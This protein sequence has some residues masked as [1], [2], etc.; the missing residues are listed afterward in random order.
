MCNPFLCHFYRKYGDNIFLTHTYKYPLGTTATRKDCPIYIWSERQFTLIDHVKCLNSYHIERFEIDHEM[1]LAVANF[2]DDNGKTDI[3]S[4]IYKYDHRTQSFQQ[5]QK[6]ETH[7]VDD[8]RHF[9]FTY[10]VTHDDYLIVANAFEVDETG[11]KNYETSSV[12]YKF[13]NGYFIPLQSMV[14]DHVTHVLPVIGKNHEFLLLAACENK[15]V[16]IYQ[17]DGWNFVESTIDYTRLAFGDGVTSLRAYNNFAKAT[18]IGEFFN[19]YD[20]RT[21]I[22]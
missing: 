8:I 14:F 6:I 20:L 18:L 2:E 16:Q 21:Q 15:P 5:Y 11:A 1:Y 13:I 19:F 22:H 7:A 12:I 17:Y 3:F 4:Y 9:E 10:G